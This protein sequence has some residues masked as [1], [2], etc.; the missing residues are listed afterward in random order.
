M[1]LIFSYNWL[2]LLILTVP[3]YMKKKYSTTNSDDFYTTIANITK[4]RQPQLGLGLPLVVNG[5]TL[6]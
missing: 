5:D 2:T 1:R 6:C 4:Y 3:H